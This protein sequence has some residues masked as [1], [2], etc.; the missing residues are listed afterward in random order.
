MRRVKDRTTSYAKL[1]VSGQKLCGRSE[2]L[3]CKRHLDDLDRHD[4]P[5]IFDVKEA[6]RHIDIA[7]EL[8]LGE[9]TAAIK[10]I[11]WPFQE[12]ILGNL[13][14][15][16]KKRSKERRYREAYIGMGRQNGKDVLAG[17]IANDFA[18]FSGYRYGRIFCTATKQAQALIAWRELQKFILSDKD[19][20]ALY[21]VKEYENLIISLVTGTYIQAV[22]RD[23]K[24]AD[25]FRSILA[26]ID[27]Y[28]A[29]KS[30]QMY[31]LMHDGQITV[32]SALTLAITTAGFH[33]NWPCYKL[34]QF[35]K[36][37]LEGAV[38]KDSQFVYIAEMDKED[39]IWDALNWAKANPFYL[40]NRD[41]TINE[42]MLARLAESAINAKE[43]G[44]EDLVNFE[45]KNL[46]TWVE[47]SG[48]KLIDV[49]RWQQCGHD[50]TL[51]QIATGD[52]AT[53]DCYL[54]VDLSQ[55]GDLTSIALIFPLHGEN[56]IYIW[57]HS[58]MPERRLEEHED[59][60]KVPYRQW[61]KDGLLTLTSGMYGI[62]TDYTFII[63]E[64]KNLIEKYSLN[65]LETGY[66]PANASAFLGQLNEIVP[67]NL[68]E[69]TQSA[70]SLS[71]ATNDFAL[72]VRAGQVMYDKKNA[73]LT[74]SVINAI[75]CKN[76]YGEIKVD[77]LN[78]EERI[79][80]VDCII[81][82]WKIYFIGKGSITNQA[83]EDA[84]EAFKAIVAAQKERKT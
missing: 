80:T 72:S 9:G 26:I 13:F 4:Y 62:K 33:L 53:K 37:V 5:Y 30:D 69:I 8:T 21:Q 18:N 11:A 35:C 44:G 43:L 52:S 15:W 81:D 19:L 36:Q 3:S 61:S 55:G 38:K 40:W 34:Y 67:S 59:T 57:S 73:L 74:W 16:R 54:G 78:Q 83:D 82:A 32:D 41:N 51:E 42:K 29:H 7:N 50:L 48:G 31:K 45:T 56:K 84:Y 12:F 27:E 14:G 70:K 46:N 47:Y 77:K 1:I 22:G 28:H 68:T 23:T 17:I 24:S 75:T 39:D 20:A 10:F 66:D 65:I 63:S 6:E 60:D 58:Y 79:D 71:D 49:G 2:Y 64:L 25:G 76:G